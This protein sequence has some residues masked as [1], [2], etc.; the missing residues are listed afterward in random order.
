[1]HPQTMIF[2]DLVFDLLASEENSKMISKG[3][4]EAM[5][6]S[7]TDI[8]NAEKEIERIKGEREND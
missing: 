8:Y 4:M 2:V 7:A 6:E 1:M 5:Y 3:F